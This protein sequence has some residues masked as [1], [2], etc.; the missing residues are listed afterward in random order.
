MRFSRNLRRR[1]SMK[2]ASLVKFS[3]R[4]KSCTPTRSRA[5]KALSM[6]TRTPSLPRACGEA[7]ARQGQ[8]RQVK[9]RPRLLPH[10]QDVAGRGTWTQATE[11]VWDICLGHMG[12]AQSPQEHQGPSRHRTSA[13]NSEKSRI[14]WRKVGQE[15]ELQGTAERMLC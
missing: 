10:L 8:S 9:A 5:V 12:H 15:K 11:H 1:F 3:R 14:V 13:W 2:A 6:V 4:T 7:A